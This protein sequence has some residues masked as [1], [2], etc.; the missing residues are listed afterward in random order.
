MFPQYK[1]HIIIGNND[2]GQIFDLKLGNLPEGTSVLSNTMIGD[3][4][5]SGG[6][7]GI[8]Q[9]PEGAIYA[10]YGGYA[11]NG[12][13][14]RLWKNPDTVSVTPGDSQI[15]CLDT[16][17]L[18]HADTAAN[19]AYQWTTNGNNIAGATN[20]DYSPN[21]TGM[22]TV[23]VTDIASGCFISA[24]SV[25]VTVTICS[26]IKEIAADY[27][28]V[29]PNPSN[30]EFT[31]ALKCNAAVSILNAE[32]KKIVEMKSVTPGTFKTGKEL[33]PGIYFLEIKTKDGKKFSQKLLKN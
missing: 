12:A 4:T 19:Y 33:K 5:T 29:Y 10:M 6:L 22:Y 30:S 7:T 25:Q 8:Q 18:L 11:P 31:V 28:S 9:G 16:V 24:D 26:S 15:I 27:F 23:S 32:G 21:A 3:V 17:T 13:I 2:Q 14:Y 20:A 1:N